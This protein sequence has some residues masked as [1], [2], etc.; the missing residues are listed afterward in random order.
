MNLFKGLNMKNGQTM[1]LTKIAAVVLSSSLVFACGDDLE[2]KEP[3]N[4]TPDVVVDDNTDSEV[5]NPVEANQFASIADT[6]TDD[7]GEL[8][9]SLDDKIADGKLNVSLSYDS[10]ETEAAFITIFSD[11]GNST[12]SSNQLVDFR[13]DS[14]VITLRGVD[15]DLGTFTTGSFVDIEVTWSINNDLD[16]S[17]GLA[18]AEIALTVDGEEI[19][20]QTVSYVPSEDNEGAATVAVRYNAN[21]ATT[22]FTLSADDL[23]ITD[24][25]TDTVVFEDDFESYTIGEQLDGVD[26]DYNGSSSEATIAGVASDSTTEVEEESSSLQVA[27]ISD[28]LTDDTGELR[29]S[30]DDA[31]AVGQVNASFLYD[32]EETES[33]YLAVFSDGGTSTGSSNHIADLKL[34][35]GKI[36][37]RNQE[38][39]LATFTAGEW[40][41]IQ[42]NWVTNGT[43][44]ATVTLTV[45][46]VEAGEYTNTYVPSDDDLGAKTV[47][48]RYLSNGSTTEFTAYLD[49]LTISSDGSEVFSDDFEGYVVGEEL[50]GTGDPYTS[51]SSEAVVADQPTL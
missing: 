13:F 39:T 36:S 5:D 30:L 50:E 29:Y 9:Y 15:G 27:G 38:G 32:A 41:D 18:T 28:T 24:T 49:D 2:F 1:K 17:T 47:Q 25:A 44:T 42:L 34:D 16:A 40:T 6:L 51:N 46:G 7:T 4:D 3:S 8:R 43:A 37:L 22:E 20:T 21:S 23:I 12:S 33:L 45:N 14:G 19:T 10:A 35:E 31:I 26:D 11:G 48:V